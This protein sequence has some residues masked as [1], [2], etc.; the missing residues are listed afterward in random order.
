LLAE[1]VGHQCAADREVGVV[2]TGV[3]RTEQVGESVG[4]A[5]EADNVVTVP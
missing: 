1:H 4:K 2:Q 3:V 5:A